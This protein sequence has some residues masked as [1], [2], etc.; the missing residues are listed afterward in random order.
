YSDNNPIIVY[1]CN[2][3]ASCIKQ[4]WFTLSMLILPS[5]HGMNLASIY[6][7]DDMITLTIEPIRVEDQA[8]QQHVYVRHTGLKR[9]SRLARLPRSWRANNPLAPSCRSPAR[10]TSSGRPVAP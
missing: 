8:C 7:Y 6:W 3:H 9:H 2:H 10:R 5:T 4:A 1:T